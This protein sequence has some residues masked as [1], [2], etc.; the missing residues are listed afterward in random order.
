MAMRTYVSNAWEDIEDLPVAV[1]GARE[2]ADCARIYKNN[3]WEDV[4]NSIIDMIQ[5]NNTLPSGAIVGRVQ[6]SASDSDGWAIWY[7]ENGNTGGGSVTYYIEG[8]FVNPTISFDYDGFFSYMPNG[9]MQ[10][11]SVGKL[12]IYTRDTSAYNREVYEPVISGINVQEGEEHFEKTISGSYNRIGFRFTFNNW[13][14]SSSY[15]PQYLFNIWNILIDGKECL[16]S[17]EYASS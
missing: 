13:N 2:S 3:A 7:F 5:L 14:V 15:G 16:P 10:Y 6:G 9:N 1:N 17:E 12:D 8:D 4:W 11:A